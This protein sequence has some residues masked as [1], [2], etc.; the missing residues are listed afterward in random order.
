MQAPEPLSSAAPLGR[1]NALIYRSRWFL[2]A[3]DRVAR[4]LKAAALVLLR[5]SYCKSFNVLSTGFRRPE[6]LCKVRENFRN[7]QIFNF[8]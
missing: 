4:R 3:I 6:R 2:V 8:R 1:P 7:R 5:L